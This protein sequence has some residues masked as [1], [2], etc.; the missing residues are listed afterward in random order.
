[1]ANKR[2]HHWPLLSFRSSRTRM[3]LFAVNSALRKIFDTKSQDIVNECREIFNCLS[4]ESTIASRGGNFWRKLLCH[5][6]SHAAYLLS[7][8]PKNFLRYDNRG[9]RTQLK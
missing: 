9:G 8:T 1:M 4:A 7:M 5:K 3:P 2:V 6:I